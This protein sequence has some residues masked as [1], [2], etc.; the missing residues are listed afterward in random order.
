MRVT[1][2]GPIILFDAECV[3]FGQLDH[4]AAG[5]LQ[6]TLPVD[7]TAARENS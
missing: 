5:D 4:I 3:L 6:V 1:P 7:P 2:D